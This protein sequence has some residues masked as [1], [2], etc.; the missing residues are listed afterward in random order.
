GNRQ[1]VRCSVGFTDLQQNVLA[2]DLCATCGACEVVC[3]E[4]LVVMG[5]TKPRF[6]APEAPDACGSCRQ[7]VEVCPGADAGTLA[8]EMQLFGRAR[9]REE[10]WLGISRELVR[11]RSLDRE[12]YELSSSGGCSTTVL[13]A[14]Q[15]Y[16]HVDYLVVA[17]RDPDRRWIAAPMACRSREELLGS[18]QS[19]YQLFAHLRVLKELR[20]CDPRATLALA[21]LPCQVQALRKLQ[22]MDGPVAEYARNNIKFVL[23]IACSSNT[24]RAGTERLI[25]DELDLR[26]DDVEDVKFRDGDYPGDFVVHLKDKTKRRVELW[27][28][29]EHFKKHKTHRCLSCGDWMSGLADVSVCDGDP[30]IF[31][32]SVLPD[33]RLPKHGRMLVRTPLGQAVV[34]RATEEKML[35]VWTGH[36]ARMNLG[37]E[38]KRNRRAHYE[39]A[40]VP[41]PAA[42]IAGHREE[43]EPIS[44]ERLL[45]LSLTR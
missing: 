45:Q 21:G 25:T 4:N 35:E 22:R 8:S 29:V 31:K 16:L 13:L 42:P 26:L 19:T 1:E 15:R 18:T 44:D 7:C 2:N 43:Q 9:T 12:I 34:D 27:K 33:E 38:R 37:L 36:V 39:R 10:R 11:A 5:P 20:E 14:A 40:G 28:A 32:S 30:N 24:L 41:I 17:G 3:P 6:L 23:E